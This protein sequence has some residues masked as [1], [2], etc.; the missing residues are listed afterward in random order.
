MS[1]YVREHPTAMRLLKRVF[2]FR[3]YDEGALAILANILW[4]E[5]RFEEA[6][7]LYGFAACLGDKDEGLVRSPVLG[8]SPSKQTERT[9]RFLRNRFERFGECSSQP[10]RTLYWAYTQYECAAEALAVLDHALQLRCDD[11]ELLL[12]RRSA[13]PARRFPGRRDSPARAEGHS[14]RA[15]RLR[16]AAGLAETRGDLAE[17][18]RMWQQV[19][20][21]EPLALDANRALTQLIAETEDRAAAQTHLQCACDRFPHNYALCQRRL[22]GCARKVRPFWNRRSPPPRHSPRRRLVA[23]RVGPV[24]VRS[25]PA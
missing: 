14:Q 13:E 4:D 19:V 9:L 16:V 15:A 25:G 8:R 3:P 23:P 5:R 18:R 20:D 24:S 10:S 2:R 21:A 6:L 7:E 17:A 1:A 22:G 12:S 11:G